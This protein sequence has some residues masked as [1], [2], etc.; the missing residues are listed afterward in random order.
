MEDIVFLTPKERLQRLSAELDMSIRQMAKLADMSEATLYHFTD[1]TRPVT[2]R[3]AS[4]LCYQIKKKRGLL[5]N[6]DW[7]LT[8][9][10]KMMVEV[11]PTVT[12]NTPVAAGSE[13]HEETDWKAK[14]YE[15]LEQHSALQ[16]EHLELVKK[17]NGQ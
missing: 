7:L 15:L 3:A 13:G 10:G 1:G 9:R 2:D 5:I 6:R 11:K 16:A 4:R 14:Y 17:Q 8:G 12:E